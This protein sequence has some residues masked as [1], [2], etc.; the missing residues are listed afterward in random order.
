LPT[1]SMQPCGGGGQGW[2]EVSNAGATVRYE[3]EDSGLC[4]QT[5]V[6]A[7][8]DPLTLAPCD[9]SGGQTIEVQY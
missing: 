4:L 6:P 2:R 9:G 5:I 7:A 1:V 3:H 8:P